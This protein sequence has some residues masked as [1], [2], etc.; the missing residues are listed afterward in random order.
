MISVLINPK[1]G[2]LIIVDRHIIRVEDDYEGDAALIAK[3]LAINAN[4]S[5]PLTFYLIVK[6][7]L[8]PEWL[9]FQTLCVDASKPLN[10]LDYV[11]D[12]AQV[13][14]KRGFTSPTGVT[15][16]GS[17]ITIAD[18]VTDPIEV[19]LT[20]WNG[21]KTADHAFKLVPIRDIEIPIGFKRFKIYIEGI[22]VSA[23]LLEVPTLSESLDS[24]KVDVYTISSSEIVLHNRHGRYNYRIAGNFWETH[25]LNPYGY[26][27]SI[28][29]YVEVW[30][31]RENP[32][33]TPY[34]LFQ[35]VII[36]NI[37][38]LSEV[39]VRLKASDIS[40]HLRKSD[41]RSNRLGIRKAAET[42]A[43]S[44]TAIEGVYR[45]APE[46]Q[47]A[48]A[49]DANA[50]SDRRAITL[51]D[52]ANPTISAVRDYTG[53]LTE[54]DV[55][56]EGGLLDEA[57]LMRYKTP[58]RTVPAEQ[59]LHYLSKT[60]R[61]YSV[62]A[63]IH[64]P[65][66]DEA[67]F[68]PRG[69]VAY[70]TEPGRTERVPVDW[71]YDATDKQMYILLSAPDA[72]I[73]SRLIQVDYETHRSQL[74]YEFERGRTAWQL[75][76]EDFD[77]FYILT[78]ASTDGIDRSAENAA[79]DTQQIAYAYDS[80]AP[81]SD[82]RI[83]RYHKSFDDTTDFI[84]DTVSLTPQ[85]GCHY[86]VG[87]G[88]EHYQNTYSGIQ[89]HTRSRF[90]A[91]DGSLHYRYA[92]DT[93]FGVAKA[94][95]DGT[96]VTALFTETHDAFFNHLNFAFDIDTTGDVY[97][98]SVQGTEG[99][100]TLKI[101]KYVDGA[102]NE[103]SFEKTKTLGGLTD[104]DSEGGTFLGVQELVVSSDHFYYLVPV[105]REGRRYDVCAAG[106][107]YH[108]YRPRRKH[109]LLYHYDFL[110][111]GPCALTRKDGIVYFAETPQHAY[112]LLPINPDLDT[113]DT[114]R[115][116]N[117]LDTQGSFKCI[118]AGGMLRDLG[119][120]W[121]ANEA[122]HGV[123]TRGLATDD[124]ID[125]M[126]GTG[127]PDTLA[128]PNNPLADPE[129]QQWITYTK[130]LHYYMHQIPTSG[131]P[132]QDIVN[133]AS[134][135]N[136]SFY[137]DR[138]IVKLKDNQPYSARL[139][140]TIGTTV[141]YA[142]AN[143]RFPD[144]G[145]L[146]ID[147]EILKYDSKTDTEFTGLTRHIGGTNLN[148]QAYRGEDARLTA[149][150]P[151]IGT[152]F[153]FIDKII[154]IE[155]TIESERGRSVISSG[156]I[157]DIFQSFQITQFYNQI[158]DSM[159]RVR[160]NNIED[161]AHYG[162]RTFK[163]STDL[164]SNDIDWLAWLADVYLNRLSDIN[165]QFRLRLTHALHLS[166]GDIVAFYWKDI[167]LVP[168]RIIEL[169]HSEN[170]YT[171]IVGKQ[172]KPTG[173]IPAEPALP[174]GETYRTLDGR[175]D[176]MFVDGL[177]DSVI[178]AGDAFNFGRGQIKLR[179]ESTEIPDQVFDENVPI[180][181]LHLPKAVI[182]DAGTEPDGVVYRLTGS[183]AGLAF[184]AGA[185]TL[186]GFPNTDL[187]ETAL[188][189]TATYD[190][191]SVTLTFNLT[192]NADTSGSFLTLDGFGDPFFVDGSGDSTVFNG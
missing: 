155:A 104:I 76:S 83:T 107:I 148:Q 14:W 174:A 73:A 8:T 161:L 75:A 189:Y 30:N 45:L 138:G 65:E 192:V 35:G 160:K 29:I 32:T 125:L 135:M 180:P 91:T 157:L 17:V 129:K 71:I 142:G 105:S 44:T 168:L 6:Q 16:E 158:V 81:E 1:R 90:I 131:S 87:F 5:A 181:T 123:Y 22:D 191:E 113:Y 9:R 55:R 99:G 111:W 130:K 184:D 98:A 167:F 53:F 89:P 67:F 57:V 116:Y 166:V 12:A 145:Y 10:L 2:S 59:A 7:T 13:L 82:T 122:L 173:V 112:K 42:Q 18:T 141:P 162:E 118:E 51:K 143:K 109:R 147:R 117:L 102:D 93:E 60:D 78:A 133:L 52:T 144:S 36:A 79:R 152:A 169:E 140:G 146:L 177:G 54:T 115:G 139:T 186:S 103:V 190:G 170:T 70:N 150:T 33:Y 68:S 120:I 11:L 28:E 15:L 4:G 34:L 114:E 3:L 50:Q 26:L 179:F 151:A 84:D 77:T 187:A 132:Y 31:G 110:H 74:L 66:L 188:T 96:A 171:A 19:E 119:N 134:K 172:V 47:P 95:A 149:R 128:H 106:A 176:P 92:T 121:F 21:N 183:L 69:N 20:A 101:E 43:G 185:C 159:N 178:F 64:I 85:V 80:A 61:A 62:S 72:H 38:P 127:N 94:P 156:R 41:M 100:S 182:D 88:N 58:H 37:D 49:S 126:T 56:T 164:T 86:W 124:G 48:L 137:I 97:M 153:I 46:M 40:Y 175:G 24:V 27:N 63:D 25:N 136:A 154:P 165:N 23:D 108:Y 163:L 39:R